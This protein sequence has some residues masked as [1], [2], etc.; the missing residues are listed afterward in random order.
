MRIGAQIAISS[1]EEVIQEFKDALPFSCRTTWSNVPRGGMRLFTT[2]MKDPELKANFLK[3]KQSYMNLL[4]ERAE[5][6]LKEAKEENLEVLPYKSGFF[7]TIPIGETVDKVIEELE[8]KNI[9]I[10]KFDTGIRIGLCSVPKRKIEGLARK[11]KEA[12]NKF[13]KQ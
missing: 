5:I 10:I 12:I 3:E 11:I 1:D 2:I 6:F 9:F 13:S 8:N 4:K 7:V